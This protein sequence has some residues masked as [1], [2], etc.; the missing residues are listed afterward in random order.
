MLR[1][2]LSGLTIEG[3]FILGAWLAYGAYQWWPF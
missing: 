2:I 3:V 1:G